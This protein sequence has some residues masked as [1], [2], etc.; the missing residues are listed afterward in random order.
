VE[1]EDPP[2]VTRILGPDPPP[3]PPVITASEETGLD[4]LAKPGREAERG[5]SPVVSPCQRTLP[6]LAVGDMPAG[7]AVPGKPLDAKG[8]GAGAG[9]EEVDW[10]EPCALDMAGA[11][12][13]IRGDEA[14]TSGNEAEMCRGVD[15]LCGRR[16]DSGGRSSAGEDIFACYFI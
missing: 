8:V 5:A 9:A 11:S 6:F 7:V 13:P 2:P 14:G 15:E 16:S 1:S 12:A 10:E 4:S 3:P